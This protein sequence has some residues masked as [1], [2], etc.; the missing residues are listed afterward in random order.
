MSLTEMF[1]QLDWKM[2]ASFVELK[3]EENLRLDFKLQSNSEFTNKDDIR[4]FAKALSGFANSNGGIIIWGINARKNAEGIDCAPW[5]PASSDARSERSV[6][7]LE[8]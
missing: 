7:H 6:R 5:C 3:Q 8:G 1:D 2:M 4:N